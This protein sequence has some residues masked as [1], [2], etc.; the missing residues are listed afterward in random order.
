MK[1]KCMVFFNMCII[2]AHKLTILL[3]FVTDRL[4]LYVG[5]LNLIDG[6]AYI[7]IYMI[8][9]HEQKGIRSIAAL[10]IVLSS[11]LPEKSKQ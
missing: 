9:I 8:H 10:H 5:L 11:L 1:K 4:R 7:Y 3:R 6:E 2:Y